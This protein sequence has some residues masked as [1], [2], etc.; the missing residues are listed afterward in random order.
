M[1]YWLQRNQFVCPRCG[2]VYRVQYDENEVRKASACP[3]FCGT[4]G[5]L[6]AGLKDR[7]ENA[8]QVLEFKRYWESKETYAGRVLAMAP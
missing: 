7:D 3:T 2:A 6:G 1:N 5:F 8:L 4:G